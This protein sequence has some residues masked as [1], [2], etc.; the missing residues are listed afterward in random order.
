MRPP[1]PLLVLL[2][3]LT[4]GVSVAAGARD[5]VNKPL[6]GVTGQA[7][8]FE[9]QTGQD[10]QVRQIFLGWGEGSTWGSPFAELLAGLKPIAM[11]HIG[12]DRGRA[13]RRRSHR[14]GSPRAAATPTSS[15]STRRLPRMEDRSTCASSPR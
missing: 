2:L 11:I 9:R 10:S 6:L 14:P 5:A 3:A 1:F 4:L 12:T 8:R 13:A 7:D 15:R